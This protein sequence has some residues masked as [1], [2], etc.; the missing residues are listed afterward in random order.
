MGRPRTFDEDA[1]LEQAL[2]LFWDRGYEGTALSV[3]LTRT[4]LTKSSLYKAFGSKEGLFQRVL[5]RYEDRHLSFRHEALAQE[6]P[7]AIVAAILHG[8]VDLHAGDGTPPGCLGTNAA[9]ACSPAADAI[10]CQV[11]GGREAFREI[12]R[13]R[14]AATAETAPLP[15][16]MDPDVAASLVQTMIQGL[17]VQAK[18]GASKEELDRVAD[19]FLMSWPSVAEVA[20]T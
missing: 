20:R 1:V 7:R 17:A 14:L 2:H 11:A 9:L 8:M 3:L 15:F 12:L 16:G 4:K 18:S 10:R 6:S 13:D 19:A 5:D